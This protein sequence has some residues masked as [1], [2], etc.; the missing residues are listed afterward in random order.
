MGLAQSKLDG[1]KKLEDLY[2]KQI[3]RE[4]ALKNILWEE[5]K[6]Q[7][8][9]KQ[10][11]TA[12]FELLSAL[13]IGFSLFVAC[14]Y[15]GN[16]FLIVPAIPIVLGIGYRY[17]TVFADHRKELEQEMEKIL[18][19]QKHLTL[20]PGGAIT[21]QELDRRRLAWKTHDKLI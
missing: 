19:E 15:T 7:Q 6:A 16:N 14:K 13:T 5:R 20:V 21:L 11:L 18:C 1:Y 2:S 12:P 9:A 8:L 4:I 3:E 10:R 17:E